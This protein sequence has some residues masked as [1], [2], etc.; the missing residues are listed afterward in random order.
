MHKTK[1][2]SSGYQDRRNQ[3]Y[4]RVAEDEGSKNICRFS[5]LMLG[6]GTRHSNGQS[7]TKLLV[8]TTDFCTTGA[9]PCNLRNGLA[10]SSE[11]RNGEFLLAV[12][13]RQP[14][15]GQEANRPAP[16]EITRWMPLEP[17][18]QPC[19]S[20]TVSTVRRYIHHPSALIIS[21]PGRRSSIHHRCLLVAIT[22]ILWYSR[23]RCKTRI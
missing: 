2:L 16:L 13:G 20:Y 18:S 14:S 7:R 4:F 21:I 12:H 11:S 23:R 19:F 10:A 6:Y 9:W 22:S 5:K 15:T 1:E 8:T 3:M 17:S